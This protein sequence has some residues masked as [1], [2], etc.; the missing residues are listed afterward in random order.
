L[1]FHGFTFYKNLTYLMLQISTP[2]IFF[3]YSESVNKII[4][5]NIINIVWFFSQYIDSNLVDAWIALRQYKVAFL[6][7]KTGIFLSTLID[8]FMYDIL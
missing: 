7:R 3:R 4:L 5:D 1:G 8:A 6:K 2:N